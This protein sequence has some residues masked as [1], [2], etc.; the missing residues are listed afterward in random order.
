MDEVKVQA[1][2]VSIF[3]ADV[4]DTALELRLETAENLERVVGGFF[5]IDALECGLLMNKDAERHD[6]APAYDAL[7]LAGFARAAESSFS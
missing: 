1:R 7:V 5:Y 6:Q 3:N 4:R 2:R